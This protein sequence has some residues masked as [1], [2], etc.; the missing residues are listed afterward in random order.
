MEKIKISKWLRPIYK[1]NNQYSNWFGYYTF[2]TLD[3]EHKK[4]LCN[5]AT[6][7]GCELSKGM[8]I[9]L[10]YYD[11]DNNSWHHI[12]VS[13]S[14]NWQQ[15][16][17]LQWIPNDRNRVIYNCSKNGKIISRIHDIGTGESCDLKFP[18]YDLS[19][20][21]KFAL[22]LNY[23]RSYFCRAY[24]YQSVVNKDYDVPIAEDD[25]IFRLDIETDNLSRILS[26]QEI[27]NYDHRDYFNEYKHWVEHIM[28]SPSGKRFCFLHRFSPI[29][30]VLK[31][32][33]RLCIADIDGRNLQVVPDW[34]KYSLSHF[35][36]RDEDSFCIYGVRKILANSHKSGAKR[37]NFIEFIKR[38]VLKCV[39][40]ILPSSIRKAI[41]NGDKG[42]LYYERVDQTWVL[43]EKWAHPTINID[44]HPTFCKEGRYMLTDTY[45]DKNGDQHLLI[46]NPASNKWLDLGS[47]YAHYAGNPASC[48]LHPKVS[49]DNSHVVVDTAYD[50]QHHMIA[51]SIEWER[52]IKDLAL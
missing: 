37:V 32:E 15:G 22:C 48:D 2:D 9:E 34:D 49:R 27:I 16:A 18:I 7:D 30:D 42:Y 47:F 26:I 8:E 45:P 46:Y 23:E 19:P 28:I 38:F 31:Y 25:G 14:F 12:G 10:G 29:D 1:T 6:F 39:K 51:F 24:H 5:R 43:K 50:R 36:W 35:A 21:G 44:G 33:T 3:T 40:R 41:R 52:V 13:D 4:M 20:D 11:T 17:M